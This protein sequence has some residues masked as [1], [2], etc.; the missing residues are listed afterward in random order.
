MSASLALQKAMR[1]A[2]IARPE[3]LALVPAPAILD[4]N[5]RP[6]PRPSIIIGECS[7]VA[8]D[9]ATGGDVDLI[10]DLH[11]WV[12]ESSLTKARLIGWEV[13]QA[14]RYRVAL[15]GGFH[16]AGWDS[17]ARYLRDPDGVTS[18]GIVT[19]RARVTGGGL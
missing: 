18:H 14:L 8:G 1:G 19:V 16:L 5:A 12:E 10:A 15:S 9:L 7:E 3:L 4:R 17:T 6:N 13:R 2:M 11:I